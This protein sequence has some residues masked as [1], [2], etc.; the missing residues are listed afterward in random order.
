MFSC[1]ANKKEL[2]AK[3]LNKACLEHTKN[4]W[5]LE[6]PYDIR[7]EAMAD[8]LKAIKSN[9]AAIKVKQKKKF[10][11]KFRTRKDD[12]QAITVLKRGLHGLDLSPEIVFL[13]SR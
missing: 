7:D 1:K 5:A 13:L 3:F 2:R 8:V 4:A 6:T 11:L 9:V 12:S 10:Y